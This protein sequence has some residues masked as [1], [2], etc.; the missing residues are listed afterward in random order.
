MIARTESHSGWIAKDIISLAEHWANQKFPYE[1]G[2]MLLGYIAENNDPVITNLIGAGPKAIHQT[3]YFLPD[4]EYQ[5]HQLN[6]IFYETSGQV[7][8][9][10]EWHTHP[11]SDPVPSG[12]DKQTLMRI[13]KAP[14]SCI[15]QP[16][17]MIL[18]NGN[19]KW[20]A[21][22]FQSRSKMKLFCIRKYYLHRLSLM[23][24]D[25]AV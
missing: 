19:K 25:C 8:Y 2:G 21:A 9:L 18:G 13:A 10:G 17:M 12:L 11:L 4:A 20:N 22:L 7:T 1:T 5:Q 24:Y 15:E 16:L 3:N 6:T 23:R 14:E